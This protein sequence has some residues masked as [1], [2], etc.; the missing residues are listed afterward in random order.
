MCGTSY[1]S[2]VFDWDT[3]SFQPWIRIGVRGKRSTMTTS[4]GS[5]WTRGVPPK[6]FTKGKYGFLTF[7]LVY[8]DAHMA[9]FKHI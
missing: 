6:S 8:S 3:N 5:C 9:L 1:L 2:V 7:N 4:A